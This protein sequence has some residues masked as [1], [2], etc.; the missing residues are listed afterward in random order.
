MIHKS[1]RIVLLLRLVVQLSKRVHWQD[2]IIKII[3]DIYLS[4]LS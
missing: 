1:I 2:L 3:L 4:N